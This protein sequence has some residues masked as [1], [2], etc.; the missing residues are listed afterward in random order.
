MGWI[1][2]LLLLLA[3]YFA[4]AQSVPNG[5]SII[6]GQGWTIPQ[7][8]NA[9]QSKFDA[10]AGVSTNGTFSN[11]T[12]NGG[13]LNNIAISGNL[14]TST[15][16]AN[17]SVTARALSERFAQVINVKDY[18]AKGDGV[19]DDSAAIAA[20]ENVAVSQIN[21]LRAAI[22]FPAGTYILG[23]AASL[24]TVTKPIRIYGDGLHKTYIQV[25]TSYVGDIFPVSDV[26][27]GAAYTSGMSP[28]VDNAGFVLD[29]LTVMGTTTSSNINNG[30]A[31]YDRNDFSL[32]QNVSFYYIT[33]SC[34]TSGKT[35]NQ[36]A[37]FL[38][39]SQIYN[40]RC[41]YTGS[42]TQAA[43]DLSS[44]T[45]PGGESTNELHVFGL[46]LFG[47][48][49]VGLRITNPLSNVSSG[50]FYF[51]S[52]V[53]EYSGADDIDI[54]SPTDTGQ[55]N[56]VHLYGVQAITPGQTNAGFYGI[57]VDTNTPQLFSIDVFG[58]SIGPCAAATTCNGLYI[59]NV[60]L[61][62]FQLDG[63]AVSGTDVTYGSNVGGNVLLDGSGAEQTWTY[64]FGS[65]AQAKA[66]TPLAKYG[67]PTVANGTGAASVTTAYHDGSGTFG[68]SPGAGAVDLQFNRLVNTQVASGNLSCLVAGGQST[69][70]GT[71]ACVVA[72]VG[73]VVSGTN[74]FIGGGA[75]A[76]D[77]GRF[78]TQAFGAGQL[79]VVGDAQA[80][81]FVLS[82]T[83]A[84]C[85]STQLSAN[86]A[87]PNAANIA[88]IS[89]GQSYAMSWRC[90]ARDVTTAGTDN[91]TLMP[92]MLMS[93]DFSAA[94][95]AV[96]LGTPATAT[97]G[98]WTGGG[99][100]FGADTTNGGMNIAFT[101]PTGNTDTF[102][103]V[104]EGHDAETQ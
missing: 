55:I 57:K 30:I 54:G 29:D 70:S 45:I 74:G 28:S 75:N 51:W 22:Y 56:D 68:S 63:I 11:P 78:G 41:N 67:D 43:V 2:A 4:E 94:S 65:G 18:G 58:G 81:H 64:S 49:S 59:G 53:V 66:K 40:L 33:G 16:I 79:S 89:N 95:T 46:R 20:A 39:E 84:S 61:A 104:C 100:N 96:S 72:G 87:T 9:W 27:Q 69:A 14:S 35:K 26:W 76:I 62:R 32:I 38:R 83:C 71:D 82:A 42:A 97:R 60:R 86:H 31:Y 48:K 1:F 21:G 102:H 8:L 6:G 85:S 92:V 34:L 50:E 99:F 88:N 52:P 77:R 37:A 101:S 7:W 47:S 73:N 80:S 12:I 5:G 19:T 24:P 44:T 23:A 25:L 98:T 10:T 36:T 91:A 103:A 13:S 3:P 90:I 93:R 17:S 15:V